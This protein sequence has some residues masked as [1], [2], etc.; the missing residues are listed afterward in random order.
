MAE[1]HLLNP[2][3]LKELHKHEKKNDT[4][5]TIMEIKIVHTAR[6]C[7][8]ESVTMNQYPDGLYEFINGWGKR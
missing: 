3:F 7:K 1:K 8:I 2:E 5:V 4:G 6:R